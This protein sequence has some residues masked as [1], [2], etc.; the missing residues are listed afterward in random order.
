MAV[1]GGSSYDSAAVSSGSIEQMRAGKLLLF[2]FAP[3]VYAAQVDDFYW[4]DNHVGA[5]IVDVMI[6]INRQMLR[7]QEEGAP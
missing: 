5:P 6:T 1:A 4:W 2:R 7:Q 3:S